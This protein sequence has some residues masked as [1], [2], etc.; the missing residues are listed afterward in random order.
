MTKKDLTVEMTFAWTFNKKDWS[1][2]KKHIQ[3]MHDHPQIVF[4]YDLMNSFH[5]LN[6]ITTP[7]LKTIKVTDAN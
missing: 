1:D 6:D 4:G 7:K 5:C 2:E 3:E